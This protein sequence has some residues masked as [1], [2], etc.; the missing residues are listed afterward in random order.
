[1]NSPMGTFVGSMGFSMKSVVSSVNLLE[2]ASFTWE[3]SW[4]FVE[5]ILWQLLVTFACILACCFSFTLLPGI[6]SVVSAERSKSWAKAITSRAAVSASPKP[7]VNAETS[8]LPP[9]FGLECNRN[10]SYVNQSSKVVNKFYNLTFTYITLNLTSFTFT[11][12]AI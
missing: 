10:N 2:L 12:A 7:A 5:G 8:V 6:P 3:F 4:T 11:N 1:M 9:T